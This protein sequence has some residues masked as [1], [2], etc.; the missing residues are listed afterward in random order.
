[1]TMVLF[2]KA[3]SSKELLNAK[4]ASTSNKMALTIRAKSSWIKHME[5]EPLSVKKSATMVSGSK[6]ILMARED[7]FIQG[8]LIMRDSLRWVKSMERED[9][10]GVLTTSMKENLRTISWKDWV[11][12]WQSN[13]SMKVNLKMGIRM[14]KGGWKIW[15]SNGNIMG[16]SSKI[17]S[18]EK[19]HINGLMGQ[20]LKEILWIIKKLKVASLLPMEK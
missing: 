16:S 9:T 1:M 13:L 10:I 18:M 8:V 3:A 7:K 12:M 2:I 6:I 19:G 11:R 17:N 14:A 4:M 15:W 20:N 5:K